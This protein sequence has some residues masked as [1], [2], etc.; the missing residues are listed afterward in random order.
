MDLSVQCNANMTDLPR[1]GENAVYAC[2]QCRTKEDRVGATSSGTG[3][4]GAPGQPGGSVQPECLAAC[5]V[6]AKP[7]FGLA[8]A[9]QHPTNRYMILF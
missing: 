6:G 5:A 4:E 2:A 9:A 3:R 7:P 8:T 1:A